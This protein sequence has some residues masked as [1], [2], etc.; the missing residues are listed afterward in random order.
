[1]TVQSPILTD[2]RLEDRYT[3]TQGRVFLTGTQAI[4][5]IALDQAR[6]DRAR[7]NTHASRRQRGAPRCPRPCDPLTD[8]HTNGP[9]KTGSAPV[10]TRT[11]LSRKGGGCASPPFC[12]N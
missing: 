8:G 6:R 1:M 11:N 3:R 12:S 10:H 2:Y 7:A 9:N 5:R 4:V